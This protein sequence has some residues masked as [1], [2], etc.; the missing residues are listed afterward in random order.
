M[1]EF[2]TEIVTPEMHS[3]THNG[4][5]HSWELHKAM[6]QKGWLRGAIPKYL[7]GGGRDPMETA[8]LTEELQLAAAPVDSLGNVIM[9]ASVILELGNNFL[10]DTV[11]P[12]LLDGESLMALGYSEPET[13]SDVAAAATKAER[14]G[15]IWVINGQKMWTT[16]AHESDFVILLTRTNTEVPKHKGLTMFI[17]PLDTP[18][19]EVQPIYTMGHDRTNATFYDSV[20][21]EDKWRIGEVDEGW[22]VMTAC[23]KYERGI[24][25]G[26]YPSAHLLDLAVDY[27]K[28]QMRPDKSLPIDD[29]IVRE[30]LV[31]GMIDLEICKVLAYRTAY[32]ASKGEFFGVEGSMTK[33]YSSET[34]K[35]H[36]NWFIEMMGPEG[37][38]KREA[39]GSFEEGLIEQHWRHAPVT[40]IYGGTS[41][42]QRNNIAERHMGLPKAR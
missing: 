5:I 12:K 19:I 31:R 29:P 41:E 23:L 33:L 11:V 3:Q 32:L 35:K 9:I 15:D 6:A 28:T 13:G 4:T 36:S 21:L 42:I 24:A 14:D 17:T 22:Q 1:R 25:G 40:T 26:Q 30:R 2:L 34:Y 10:K 27:A 39:E 38:L 20:E 18:G 37:L 7:G 16:M 8:I